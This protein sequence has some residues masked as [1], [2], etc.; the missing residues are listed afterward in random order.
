MVR[1]GERRDLH[2]VIDA[3]GARGSNG[4]VLQL[5][6]VF[7]IVCEQEQRPGSIERRGQRLWLAQ[8]AAGL[9][10]AWHPPNLLHVASQRARR[11]TGPG[12]S[13][14]DLAANQTGT[15]SDENH[16]QASRGIPN[17]DQWTLSLAP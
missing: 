15:S 8:I 10:D 7:K 14:Q 1:G 12:E 11:Y 9:C 5:H 2:D 13:V 17:Q 16:R 3:S 6:H 4:V